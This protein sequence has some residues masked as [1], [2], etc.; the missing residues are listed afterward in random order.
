MFK[1]LNLFQMA[2][3]MAVHA[4]TRQAL[5]AQNVANADTPGYVARDLVP[6]ADSYRNTSV[7]P[8]LKAT[9]EGHLNGARSFDFRVMETPAG[10]P[11]M[12]D[13]TVSIEDQMVSAVA[14][15]R[16]HD[17]ALAIYR[18]GLNMLRTSIGK[19]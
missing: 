16:Q 4:G 5:I 6:F 1:N 14:T 9:R 12:N 11:D 19:L 8:G 7:S 15:K 3:S 13:N 18:S 17:R 10:T 2:Q